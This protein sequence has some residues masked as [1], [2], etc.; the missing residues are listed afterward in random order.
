MKNLLLY[1]LIPCSAAHLNALGKARSA[2]AD[3]FN[4]LLVFH[5][6][7]ARLNSD[8][9]FVDSLDFVDRLVAVWQEML[10]EFLGVEGQTYKAHAIGHMTHYVRLLG[11]VHNYSTFSFESC[12][13][14]LSKL[15]TSAKGALQQVARRFAHDKFASSHVK[16]L[17]SSHALRPLAAILQKDSS[18]LEFGKYGSVKVLDKPKKCRLSVEESEC[19][20][21]VFQNVT[22]VSCFKQAKVGGIFI[23]CDEESSSCT[24][25]VKVLEG[26]SE[27]FFS[28]TRMFLMGNNTYA[29]CKQFVILRFLV[30][31]VVK[32]KNPLLRELWSSWDEHRHNKPYGNFFYV[33]ELSQELR[34]IELRN[35]I[36]RGILITL[37]DCDV[38]VPEFMKYE[39]N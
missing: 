38:L 30:D 10:P 13:G 27:N 8:C 20:G 4:W 33:V 19:I 35:V 7:A 37:S 17:E 32:P 1:G 9:I 18:K 3:F 24:H 28:V 36:G 25:I 11:P 2:A 5:E 21:T 34:L 31:D 29:F 6:I 39:H 23:K 26:S 15:V 12:N 14:V 22:E 16:K